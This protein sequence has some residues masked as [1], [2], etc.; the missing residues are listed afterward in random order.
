MGEANSRPRP[1]PVP[2]GDRLRQFAAFLRAPG[3]RLH[4][5]GFVLCVA[6]FLWQGSIYWEAVI[7]DAY[8][9]FRF[10]DN[11]A[12]GFGLRFN[13]GGPRVEGY[14]NF[15]WVLLCA[16]ALRAGWDVLLFAKLAGLACAVATM[17]VAWRWCAAMRGRDDA[18][19]LLA[20]AVLAAN[21]HFAHWAVM[22]L[23]TP[24]AT[25]L[26]LATFARFDLEMR[27]PARRLFSPLLA[28]L[29]AMTRIDSLLFLCPVGI[30]GAWLVLAGRLPVRRMLAWGVLA[31]LPFG[32]YQAWRVSYFGELLPNTYY[33][34]QRLVDIQP[35]RA[36]GLFQFER[37]FTHQADGLPMSPRRELAVAREGAAGLFEAAR[38]GFA[39]RVGQGAAWLVTGAGMASFWWMNWC[40]GALVIL[41]AWPRPRGVCL[42]V[43]PVAA[44]AYFV[45]HVDGD[46]MPN[47]RFFQQTL[48]FL[49]VAGP[50]ALAMAE[51]AWLGGRAWRLAARGLVCAAAL[52]IAAEQAR[53]GY[54]Y[55]FGRDP[56]DIPRVAGW[57]RPS[58]VW[59]AYRR[60]FSEPLAE[61]S[62]HLLLNT[63]DGASIFMSDIGQPLWF[64]GHL[65]LYDACG[66]CDRKLAHAPSERG[67]IARA[68]DHLR[69]LVAAESTP[70]DALRMEQLRLMARRREFDAH[71]AR[72]ARYILD[73]ARPE[74]LLI[75]LNHPDG[76]TGGTGYPY[77]EISAAIH[78]DAV[79]ERDYEPV[80]RGMKIPNVWNVLYRR[81]DVPAEVAP[82][83]RAARLLRVLER[84]PRLHEMVAVAMREGL[85]MPDGDARERLLGRV[86]ALVPGAVRNPRAAAAM[87]AVARAAKDDA[88][89]ARV[90]ELWGREDPG[91]LDRVRA[92]SGLLWMDGKA[93]EAVALLAGE[94]SRFGAEANDLRVALAYY[95]E[96]IG[97]LRAA[98]DAVV[99]AVRL[100]PGNPALADSLA[101]IGH[102]VY[103]TP[104]IEGDPATRELALR[105][106]IEGYR[107]TAPGKPSVR[108]VLEEL[109]RER[110]EGRAAP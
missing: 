32:A 77:P 63:Q 85:A 14:S 107:R 29:A 51:R 96:S 62:R 25:L 20:P 9:S 72:N 102:R 54:V 59:H 13:G 39:A 3:N 86:D 66:L 92:E 34:K 31:A 71:I 35:E 101:T 52:G 94:L 1:A 15:T 10:A 61:V 103:R 37:F 81:R 105:A 27:D 93:A 7:D 2:P 83:V 84:N 47:Y 87:L 90:R 46:W 82:E 12:R 69:E 30:L 53:V 98:I 78:R 5:A 41:L 19:A 40:L 11:L 38:P 58:S 60:G 44:L 74:Y 79:R 99:E 8:I 68:E 110:D 56:I 88:R 65:A 64:C 33:A 21:S 48:P 106:A 80:W 4:L 108:G 28:V 24:L 95:A 104:G 22:G 73:D 75:F 89:A 57:W 36:R 76:D 43:L 17:W 49:A 18:L 55:I 23:E 42:L 91:S 45:D 97:S 67:G 70:P 16:G 109:E 50:V 100:D 26:V 6:W